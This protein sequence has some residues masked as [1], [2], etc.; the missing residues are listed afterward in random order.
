[1]RKRDFDDW[2]SDIGYLTASLRALEITLTNQLAQ[3]RMVTLLGRK[4]TGFM[5]EKREEIIW[6]LQRAIHAI[7]DSRCET[8]EVERKAIAKH[9]ARKE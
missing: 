4:N 9:L 8:L 6:H 2:R 7:E 1:M 3:A 5:P